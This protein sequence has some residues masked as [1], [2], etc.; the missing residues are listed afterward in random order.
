MNKNNNKKTKS[1]KKVEWKH[2]HSAR[3]PYN[4]LKIS[5]RRIRIAQNWHVC[6]EKKQKK[7]NR[8]AVL[9]LSFSFG[10]WVYM[11]KVHT[12]METPLH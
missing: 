7:K 9:C 3:N 5:D 6:T 8:V 11:H 12:C 10:V 2:K 1:E 4:L